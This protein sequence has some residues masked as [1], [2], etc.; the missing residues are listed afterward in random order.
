[1]I[2]H[3]K[4]KRNLTGTGTVITMPKKNGCRFESDQ[5]FPETL[6]EYISVMVEVSSDIWNCLLG[7]TI[8]T[9]VA[10]EHLP[11]LTFANNDSLDMSIIIN[12]IAQHSTCELA[13]CFKY[14]F[15]A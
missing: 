13:H 9:I 8:N 2:A 10:L 3:S 12:K 14:P 15:S 4:A 11:S 5:T 6:T 1:L 7:N